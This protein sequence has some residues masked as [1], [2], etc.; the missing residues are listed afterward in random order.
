MKSGKWG[1]ADLPPYVLKQAEQLKSTP[2]TDWVSFC[3]QGTEYLIAKL[4]DDPKHFR[5]VICQV[6]EGGVEK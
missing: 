1:K 4:Y 5:I 2:N 6:L 3:E